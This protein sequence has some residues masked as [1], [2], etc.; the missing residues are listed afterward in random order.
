MTRKGSVWG[1]EL[2]ERTNYRCY[3]GRL[4]SCTNRFVLIGGPMMGQFSLLGAQYCA[5]N[6]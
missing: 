2:Q 5:D 6:G 4:A 1:S 3:P